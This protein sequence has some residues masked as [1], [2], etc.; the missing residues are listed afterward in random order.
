M[1]KYNL[2][3]TTSFQDTNGKHTELL[4]SKNWHID[5]LRGPLKKDILLPIIHN[6]DGVICGND[7]YDHEVL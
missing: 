5:Y 1:M 2:V 7:E 4:N 3:T 6:Y